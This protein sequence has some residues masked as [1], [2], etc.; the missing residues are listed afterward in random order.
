MSGQTHLVTSIVLH[1]NMPGQVDFTQYRRCHFA[2][3]LPSNDVWQQLSGRIP[4]RR[5]SSSGGSGGIDSSAGGDSADLLGVPDILPPP[6]LSP[7]ARLEVAVGD[8]VTIDS[9]LHTGSMAWS[10]LCS[11]LGRVDEV[12][13]ED[14]AVRIVESV[15]NPFG[16]T[17]LYNHGCV[18]FEVMGNNHLATVTVFSPDHDR[19]SL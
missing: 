10:D 4:V 8:A 3:H 13:A 17:R 6:Q 16:P 5:N 7:S 15:E 12:D 9:S 2:L 18:I 1:T 11:V 19:H 14:V